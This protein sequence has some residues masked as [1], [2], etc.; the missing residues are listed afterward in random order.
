MYTQ[1]NQIQ[2]EA[3]VVIGAV[4]QFSISTTDHVHPLNCCAQTYN[5]TLTWLAS[6]GL[7]TV[8]A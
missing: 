6:K 4:F 3:I 8:L 1:H 2:S 7:E 5:D